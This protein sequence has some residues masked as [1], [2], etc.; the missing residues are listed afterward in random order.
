MGRKPRLRPLRAIVV[1]GLLL[2]SQA[3]AVDI[4][5]CG[6]RVP[7]LGTGVLQADLVC[8]FPSAVVLDPGATLDMNGH[9]ISLSGVLEWGIGAVHCEG[10]CA[11]HGPGEIVGRFGGIQLQ[12]TIGRP[13]R[14]LEVRDVGIRDATFGIRDEY[15]FANVRATNV[16]VTNCR[17]A[18][19]TVGKLAASNV[20]SSGNERGVVFIRSLK[21]RGLTV[22]DNRERGIWGS[23]VVRSRLKAIDLVATGNGSIGVDVVSARLVDSTVTGNDSAGNAIDVSTMAR[24]RLVRS[25][26]GHSFRNVPPDFGTWG[27]C[28]GD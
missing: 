19:F 18:G 13:A 17:G 9:T 22:S 24:P 26:C 8:E 2:A 3:A 1:V 5:A 25:T 6:T 28:T 14:R 15:G 27:V 7:A 4:T 12:S 23:T 21:A 10:D 20:V 16:S 11:V